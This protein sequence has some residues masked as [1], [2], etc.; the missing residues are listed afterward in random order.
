MSFAIK[1]GPGAGS[2][3]GVST[4]NGQSGAL[5]LLAGTNITIT[6]GAGTL[7]IDATGGGLSNPLPNDT[8]LNGRNAANSANIPIIKVATDDK[9]IFG[10]QN[11]NGIELEANK[12]VVRLITNS[13]SGT[14]DI[15]A[16]DTY[17]TATGGSQQVLHF[18]DSTNANGIAIKAPNVLSAGF[19]LQLPDSPGLLGQF[20]TTNG[21][22]DLSWSSGSSGATTALDNLASVA[23]NTD[24]IFAG[25][26]GWQ[27]KTADGGSN[28]QSI[29]ITSGTP[30]VDGDAG[31][32]IIST[33][34]ATGTGSS[35]DIILIPGSSAG[36]YDGRIFLSGALQL[37]ALNTA[38]GT[39]GN[40]T[41]DYPS[42]TVNFA[43]T[44]SSLTVTNNLVTADSIVFAVV[45]TNDTAAVIKNV[46]PSSGSFIITLNAA[47]VA[48]TSVGFLVINQ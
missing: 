10:Y 8:Y 7:T 12:T 1:I 22:G 27:I 11:E 9:Q 5:T 42:G 19:T 24:L 35:A 45:R 28:T 38:G 47:A 33:G 41:I 17:L 31:A 36:G 13:G 46:V 16:S 37:L 44:A 30:D 48:E 40:Q 25:G 21:S 20:L 23:I 39:T 6:P 26:T 32:T 14:F 34:S 29:T 18:Q 43:A 15:H 3:G 4:I 2:G